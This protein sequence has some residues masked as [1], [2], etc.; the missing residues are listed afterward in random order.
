VSRTLLA[1]LSLPR[2]LALAPVPALERLVTESLRRQKPGTALRA[3]G[4]L[5]LLVVLG[6]G[7]SY[8]YFATLPPGAALPNDCASRVPAT[9]ERRPENDV[10]NHT[11]GITGV[12]VDGASAGFMSRLGHRVDGSFTGTTDEILQWGACKWGLDEDIQRARAVTESSWRQSQLGDYTTSASVCALIGKSAPCYQSYGLFQ[13]KGTVHEGTYPT[14]ELSTPFNVD[15]ALAW[16]R[17]CWEGDFTW[18]GGAYRAGDIWGCVGAWYSGGWYDAGAQGYINT[19]QTHL[20]NRTWESY[21]TYTLTAAPDTVAPGQAVTASWTVAS[22]SAHAKDWIGLY[23]VGTPNTSY[24]AWT[25]T[26]AALSGSFTATPS[27]PGTYEFRYL[28]NDGY[29]SVAQSDTIV[30]ANKFSIG[31][32]VQVTAKLNVRKA[33]NGR[34]LGTQAIGAVGTVIGGPTVSGGLVWYNIDYNRAPDGWSIQDSL[35]KVT[36]AQ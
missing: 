19:V 34:N 13:V 14:S 33:P 28:I 4:A 2:L 29:T 11:I 9:A 1:T 5:V 7:A 6:P 36:T 27:A 25:Y 17:A 35:E 20:A 23:K 26:N 15:Y 8:G 18:L 24:L 16:Q 3:L 10:A 12:H 21:S 22:G 32:R 31:D 30:V